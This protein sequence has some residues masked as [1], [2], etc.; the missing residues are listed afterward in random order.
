MKCIISIPFIG[1]CNII[2]EKLIVKEFIQHEANVKN[3]TQEILR[4]LSDDIYR[5]N[6]VKNLKNIQSKLGSSG[7][8]EKAA[9]ALLSLLQE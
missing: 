4:I 8:S 7:G 2:A 6:M 1:L 3:L 5:G 9:K